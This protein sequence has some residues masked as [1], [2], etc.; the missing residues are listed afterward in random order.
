MKAPPQIDPPRYEL[1]DAAAIQALV[2]GEASQDQQRRA[3]NW[4]I[5]AA[6][7]TYDMSFSPADPH[8]TSFAEGRRFAGNQI[9]KLSK[10]DLK[11][12]AQQQES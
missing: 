3:V 8:L 6:A 9:V 1:A 4:I 12:L 11:K 7:A 10:L 2:R 5:N